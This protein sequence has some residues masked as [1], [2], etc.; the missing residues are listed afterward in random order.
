MSG[1]LMGSLKNKNMKAI[2]FNESVKAVVV[3]ADFFVNVCKVHTA[4]LAS[5][6]Y[7]GVEKLPKKLGINGVVTSHTTAQCQLYYPYEKAVNNRLKK[8]GSEANFVAQPLN[9]GQWFIYDLLIENKG[10]LYLRFYHYKGAQSKTT[11]FV[12]GRAATETETALIKA[13][14]AQRSYNSNTQ[15]DAGLDENQV[16]PRNKNVKDIICLTAGKCQYHR[17]EKPTY[18]EV[19]ANV[20]AAK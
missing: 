18:I 17:S 10:E 2:N 8:Q 13:Y 5:I 15:S 12:N 7:E 16:S 4:S 14:K 3:N 1:F 19:G 11:Y 20:Q 9:W 6:E